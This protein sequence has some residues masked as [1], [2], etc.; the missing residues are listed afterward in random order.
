MWRSKG[1]KPSFHTGFLLPLGS[2]VLLCSHPDCCV[3]LV[4]PVD[5]EALV[6]GHP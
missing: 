3:F 6:S 2:G 4:L 5:I 1:K